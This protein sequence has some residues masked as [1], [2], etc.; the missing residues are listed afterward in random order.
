MFIH[1][2]VVILYFEFSIFN[3]ILQAAGQSGTDISY[4]RAQNPEVLEEYP[5]SFVQWV[6]YGEAL[7]H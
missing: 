3:N 6:N 7:C 1:G 2:E 5:D 4:G